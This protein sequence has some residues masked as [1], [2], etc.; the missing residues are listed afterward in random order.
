MFIPLDLTADDHMPGLAPSD[1]VASAIAW[2]RDRRAQSNL[3]VRRV[4]CAV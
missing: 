2:L 4:D 1:G 3:S